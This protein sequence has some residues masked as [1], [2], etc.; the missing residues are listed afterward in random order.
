MFKCLTY[1]PV[2]RHSHS[3]EEANIIRVDRAYVLSNT[4]GDPEVLYK[5]HRLHCLVSSYKNR[6]FYSIGK[7]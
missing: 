1:L 7:F 6:P 5:V 4:E 2:S 3:F